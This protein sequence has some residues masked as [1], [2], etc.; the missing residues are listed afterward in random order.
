MA[1]I[2]TASKEWASRP[3]DQ[4]YL[5]L[6]ALKQS[7]EQR[8]NESWTNAMTT[9]KMHVTFDDDA[10]TLGLQVP[11]TGVIGELELAPTNWAFGQLAGYA[12]A[13]TKYLREKLP[14]SLAAMCL[15]WGLDN[16]PVRDQALVLAQSNGHHQVRSLTSTSYG[17]IWDID[18]VKGVERCNANGNWKVPAASYQGANPK[19]ATTLYASDR[20]VFIFLVD[21]DH[22]IEVAG[23][24]LFRGF[25]V[26]NSEVGS[27]TF[28]LTT[29]LYRYV[30]DNRI[31]WGAT[32]VKELKIRHIGGALER[33]QE[34]G[35]KALAE[36]A[37]ASPR[38]LVGAIQAAK[39]KEV[40]VKPKDSSTKS[41]KDAVAEWLQKRGFTKKQA[42]ES[43]TR[44]EEEEG[45]AASVWDLV[46][47]ATAYARSISHT[48]ERVAV[49]KLAGK[50]M[51]T[52]A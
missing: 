48:D 51:D 1:E 3:D 46:N 26:S 13:P 45:R 8:K 44:A 22:P 33:F 52:V 43:V 18:V 32:E 14:P 4:R 16:N 17:R 9:D 30:C 11:R 24:V 39:A 10:G 38:D 20:D 34:E 29:F 41:R 7:V 19:R 35:V 21:P 5:T 2:M 49:E 12:G 31:V 42:T 15:Q 6:E 36:Y 27:A 25:F 28:S 23:D 40:E 37:N 47:G 50:L